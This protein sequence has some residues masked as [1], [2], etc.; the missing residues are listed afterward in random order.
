MNL[1]SSIFNSAS[2]VPNPLPQLA[3]TWTT[4]PGAAHLVRQSSARPNLPPSPFCSVRRRNG[5]LPPK[6]PRAC[7]FR[8]AVLGLMRKRDVRTSEVLPL[9]ASRW[10]RLGLTRRRIRSTW[11]TR[12]T[13]QVPPAKFFREMDHPLHIHVFDHPCRK[14]ADRRFDPLIERL[15]HLHSQIH[16]EGHVSLSRLASHTHE[17]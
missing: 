3:C 2:G 14:K 15:S 12:Q 16:V 9:G 13:L 10:L 7:P 5:Q 4:W 8:D 6:L 17:T 1:P 11:E